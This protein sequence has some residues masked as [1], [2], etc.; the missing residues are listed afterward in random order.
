MIHN[1]LR[2][3][4]LIVAAAAGLLSSCQKA[5]EP[6]NAEVN[7]ALLPPKLCASSRDALRALGNKAVL[8]FDDEGNG[9]IEL[10]VWLSTEAAGR[11]SIGQALALH[12]ACSAR[13]PPTEQTVRVRSET[14]RV[15]MERAFQIAPQAE[16]SSE[17]VSP[18]DGE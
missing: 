6:K 16:V 14:G 10:N 12:A 15:L 9:T 7:I 5:P 2:A 1:A 18:E 11:E 13:S 8:T 4:S 17:E 3:L